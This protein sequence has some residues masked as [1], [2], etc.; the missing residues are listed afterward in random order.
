M[1]FQAMLGVNELSVKESTAS[2]SRTGTA[3][4]K[5]SVRKGKRETGKENNNS[6]I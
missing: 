4:S 5:I 3:A 6:A 1:L 2:K